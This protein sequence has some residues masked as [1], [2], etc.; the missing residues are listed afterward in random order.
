MKYYWQ[1]SENNTGPFCLLNGANTPEKNE[2]YNF[3]IQALFLTKYIIQY[4]GV[5]NYLGDPSVLTAI[6][7]P[8]NCSWQQ[9]VFTHKIPISTY[10]IV[11]DRPSY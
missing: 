8:S 5:K 1:Q 11:D 6:I 9:N 3:V 10:H 7:N 4:Q 2:K